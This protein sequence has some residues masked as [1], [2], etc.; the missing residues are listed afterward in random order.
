MKPVRAVALS[1]SNI[2]ADGL[3][4]VLAEPFEISLLRKTPHIQQK[5]KSDVARKIETY[6]NSD[7]S[8]GSTRSGVTKKSTKAAFDELC[9]VPLSHVLVPKKEAFDYRKI[10]II[11]P[12]D[13]VLFQAVSI[14]I[15]EPFEKER[16]KVARQRIYS[17][18][19]D[20][21][22]K[23][24]Q[25][26]S[27]RYNLRSYREKSTE[28]SKQKDVK[29]IVRSDIANFYDRINIHRLES[30]LLSLPNLSNK[31]VHL[32][33]QLLLH[34][35]KRNSYGIP[36][37]SNASRILAEV[38]LFNVDKALMEAGIKF[39]RFVDDYRIFSKSAAEAHSALAV[40]IELLDRE[41][42]FINTRKSSIERLEKATINDTT[43]PEKQI[44]TEKI[45]VKE[46]RIFAGYGGTIPIKYRIPTKNSQ[47]KYM[48]VKLHDLAEEIRE[49]DFA[50][51]EQLR[52][53]LYGI[54]IQGK[55]SEILSAC[56]LV[57][58][59]PQFYPL[60]V[61]MLI[62][63]AEHLPD[64]VKEKITSQLSERLLSED[65][66]PE[67]LRASLV[68]FVGSEEFFH[69]DATMS[70]VRELKR[71]AGTY[72]GR[73]AFEAVQNLTDRT[74][75]LEIREYFDRSN[76]WE[77]RRIILLMKRLLPE[78]EY[79]AWR[80]AIQPYI[81]TDYFAVEM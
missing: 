41:G 54:F 79:N 36:I 11:S 22:E 64:N 66:L 74:D 42:L 28:L 34:W 77:R 60:F 51:P 15:A 67:Y 75:A 9:L 52:D 68:R 71:N 33:N 47:K 72:L 61:D 29:Y 1:M 70:F 38:A 43:T 35:A 32:V 3:D 16:K 19:F 20:P 18:R 37:G 56:I 59:F 63:N 14:M 26:F 65:F 46:F 12:E 50:R 81:N 49:D 27:P 10:A 30:T 80:R 24:G 40:L 69:R 31:L 53:L 78:Q 76:A 73:M 62:K 2:L 58:M 4:D 5:L 6:L 7:S 13:L 25:L 45:D 23:K 55:Y 17:Y 48:K 57:E 8:S 44:E 39:L 21:K